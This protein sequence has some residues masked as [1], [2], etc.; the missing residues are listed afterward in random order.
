M[1]RL[2]C[3]AVLIQVGILTLYAQERKDSF[4]LDQV[5]VTGQFTPTDTR[6]TVN[7]V[8]VI[9][10]QQIENRGAANIGELL[11]AEAN[12][13]INQDAILG[14]VISINGLQGENVKVL[15][16]GVPVVGRL[17]SNV[18]LNQISLSNIQRIE[19]VEGAQSVI[20][21]SDASAGVINLITKKSQTKPLMST[22]SMS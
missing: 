4:A 1:N 14:G 9:G 6:S 2:S 17:N 8:K 5:V 21:G 18:D 12:I 19:I 16:D 10:R 15:I 22:Y 3:I 11:Q 7:T 20:Y 13:R